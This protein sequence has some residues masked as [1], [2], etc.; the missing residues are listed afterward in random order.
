MQLIQLNIFQMEL[1]EYIY[2]LLTYFHFYTVFLV[3]LVLLKN[4]L[5]KQRRH[6]RV[7]Y[8]EMKKIATKADIHSL[9]NSIVPNYLV[10][11]QSSLL[12]TNTSFR[13]THN[14]RAAARRYLKD[15]M[16]NPP[17]SNFSAMS[18]NASKRKLRNPAFSP[19]PVR[20]L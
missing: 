2:I 18:L 13:N 10:A 9:V 20:N 7:E 1:M 14:C 15:K 12:P 17:H 3:F 16:S 11:L 5:M 8:N 19:G 4:D 6:Y